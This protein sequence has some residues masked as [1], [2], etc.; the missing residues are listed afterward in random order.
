MANEKLNGY[1]IAKPLV[2]TYYNDQYIALPNIDAKYGPYDSIEQCLQK[3]PSSLRAIGLTV[4]IKNSENLLDEYWFEGGIED[5]N[6]KLKI[7]SGADSKILVINANVES[8]NGEVKSIKTLVEKINERFNEIDPNSGQISEEQQQAIIQRVMEAINTSDRNNAQKLI[9]E[10]K[11]VTREYINELIRNGQLTGGSSSG[12][13]T[14]QPSGVT[15]QRVREIVNEI[16]GTSITSKLVSGT[17]VADALNELSQKTNLDVT[18]VKATKGLIKSIT[19]ILTTSNTETNEVVNSFINALVSKLNG[20][21]DAKAGTGGSS[22]GSATPIVNQQLIKS[23]LDELFTNIDSNADTEEQ[24]IFNKF[25]E[26]ISYSYGDIRTSV[27]S[28]TKFRVVYQEDNYNL[29]NEW[30]KFYAATDRVLEFVLEARISKTNKDNGAI[31]ENAPILNIMSKSGAMVIDLKDA[32]SNGLLIELF[33]IA[34]T[35]SPDK[36]LTSIAKHIYKWD[37]ILESVTTSIIQSIGQGSSGQDGSVSTSK[38]FSVWTAT[39]TEVD[40]YGWSLRDLFGSDANLITPGST[41]VITA[42]L[43]LIKRDGNVGYAPFTFA[44]GT[45][46]TNTYVTVTFSRNGTFAYGNVI[47]NISQTPEPN[48]YKIKLLTD[49]DYTSIKLLYGRVDK[50]NSSVS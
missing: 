13:S 42:T 40:G 1:N 9:D 37:S 10:I 44:F 12:S 21:I 34:K 47:E 8:L 5:N 43:C 35:S 24:Y 39:G 2:L 4:A 49:N 48:S 11:R 6:L 22:S 46:Y 14:T 26:L 27:S 29:K 41:Y 16:V 20:K 7:K 18:K 19:D 23:I 17:T 36:S 15:E 38:T 50:T 45:D 33:G 25:A 3:L 30:K 32:D 28:S 31:I